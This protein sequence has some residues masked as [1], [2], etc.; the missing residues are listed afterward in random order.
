[1]KYRGYSNVEK[2]DVI[3]CKDCYHEFRISN[4]K[5][6]YWMISIGKC[7]TCGSTNLKWMPIRI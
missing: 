5:A 3:I 7:E 2:C 4:Y 1:M 6:N